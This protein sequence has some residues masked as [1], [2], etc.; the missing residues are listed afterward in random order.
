MIKCK[1]NPLGVLDYERA[2]MQC[3]CLANGHKG[4]IRA[5]SSPEFKD[6]IK[7]YEKQSKKEQKEDSKRVF[8]HDREKQE[9]ID[10]YI[11]R[12]EELKELDKNGKEWILDEEI[13]E[14]ES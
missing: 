10:Y 3:S 4:R 11:K 5:K 2:M 7:K 8:L 14:D 12:V 1:E 9:A 6:I 13:I